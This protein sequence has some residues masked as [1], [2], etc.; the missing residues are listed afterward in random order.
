ML[1]F[2]LLRPLSAGEGMCRVIMS[3]KPV[4]GPK[5]FLQTFLENMCKT[6]S[7]DQMVGALVR[8]G[9]VSL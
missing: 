6:E 9:R 5:N 4:A 8:H 7:A 1:V 3:T 2:T